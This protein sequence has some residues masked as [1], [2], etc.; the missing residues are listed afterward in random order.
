MCFTVAL[1]ELYAGFAPPGGL[2][3]P[4]LDPVR[5]MDFGDLLGEEI[6]RGRKTESPFRGPKTFVSRV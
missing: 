5:T 2:V 1:E 4:C 6:R 3:M